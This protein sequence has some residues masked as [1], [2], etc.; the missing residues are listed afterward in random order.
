MAVRD[1]HFGKILALW[2]VTVALIAEAIVN[3]AA[4]YPFALFAWLALTLSVVL[5]WQW[6]GSRAL[7]IGVETQQTR[8]YPR[9][10]CTS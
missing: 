6:L 8:K 4:D 5:T 1:W 7:P 3:E 10:G 9:L 2:A